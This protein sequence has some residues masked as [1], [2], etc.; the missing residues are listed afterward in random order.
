MVGKGIDRANFVAVLRDCKTAG[1]MPAGSGKNLRR[2]DTGIYAR[3]S[4]GRATSNTSRQDGFAGKEP[5]GLKDWRVA[6]DKFLNAVDRRRR[7]AAGFQHAGPNPENMTAKAIAGF[8]V[9]SVI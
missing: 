1:P 9:A 6:D 7:A 2:S 8:V 4:R 5:F 3:R